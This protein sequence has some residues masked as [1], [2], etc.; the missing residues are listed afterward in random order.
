MEAKG[1]IDDKTSPSTPRLAPKLPVHTSAM[2]DGAPQQYPGAC[3]LPSYSH[4]VTYNLPLQAPA[5]SILPGSIIKW[6]VD[7]AGMIQPP[8][9]KNYSDPIPLARKRTKRPG[10]F[11]SPAN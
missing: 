4:W 1:R 7:P 6:S 8:A 11:H 9:N 2:P 5:P 3:M 10:Q